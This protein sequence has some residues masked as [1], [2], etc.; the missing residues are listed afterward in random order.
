M[1]GNLLNRGGGYLLSVPAIDICEVGA[2]GGSIASVDPGGAL[3]VGPRSAGAEPGPA[4]YG[5]GGVSATLTDA[6]ACLGYLPPSG[7]LGGDVPIDLEAARDAL[8]RD[9]AEPLGLGLEAAAWAVHRIAVASMVRVVRAV[10]SERGRDPRDFALVSFG[11]NGPVHGALVAA[12]LGVRSVVVPL[13]PGLFS[14]W[15]LLRADVELGFSSTLLRRADGLPD[16]ELAAAYAALQ[17]RA[18]DDLA[19]DGYRPEQLAW[20]RYAELRYVGQSFEL[21]VAAPRAGPPDAGT[22]GRP[23]GESAP[24]SADG[25]GAVAA[26]VAAFAAEHERSYGHAFPDQPVEIVNL[27]IV[28]RIATAAPPSPSGAPSPYPL[29]EG[30]G[31][32][33]GGHAPSGPSLVTP[34]HHPLRG[35]PTLNPARRAYFGPAHGVQDAVVLTR[36]TVPTEPRR[37]P[38]IVEEYDATTVVPPDWTVRRDRDLNLILEPSP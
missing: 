36:D 21:R 19:E 20:E 22:R 9:V 12:D 1:I 17:R 4:C 2:G 14:A 35:Y 10:S 15:G 27:G 31:T 32:R 33:V 13:H 18:L 29:P 30:E 6:N 26:L 16:A 8:R 23:E 38:A 37:G 24:T 11:G 25:A 3:H 28:A 34:Q 7:L 5:R